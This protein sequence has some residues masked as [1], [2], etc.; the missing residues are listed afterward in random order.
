VFRILKAA[1]SNFGP[2]SSCRDRLFVVFRSSCRWI[3]G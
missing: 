3:P 1:S 2:D